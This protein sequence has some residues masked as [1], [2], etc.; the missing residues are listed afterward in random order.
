MLA[1][2]AF[3]RLNPLLPKNVQRWPQVHVFGAADSAKL[4][5]LTTGHLCVPTSWCD[6]PRCG[7]TQVG[8]FALRATY[9]REKAWH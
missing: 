2:N 4:C 1:T 6:Q 3:M 5:G 7:S 9:S 8:A